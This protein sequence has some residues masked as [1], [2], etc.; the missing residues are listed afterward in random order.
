MI[1][2]LV[3]DAENSTSDG[4][5][6]CLSKE[7][8]I[9]IV[10]CVASQVEAIA[11][12]DA[13]DLMLVSGNLPEDGAYQLTRRVTRDQDC[14]NV[15]IL[16]TNEPKAAIIRFLEAGAMGY[17]RRSSPPEEILNQIYSVYRGEALV[18]PD[19]AAA[20][21]VRLADLTSWFEG[22]NL[23]AIEAQNLTR[24]ERE[25]LYLIGR[26]FS[27]QDIANHL[28]IEVGTVKN[29]V[30][31]ILAKLNVSSR[32]E[33]ATYLNLLKTVP[34]QGVRAPWLQ[35]SDNLIS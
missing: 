20:I 34:Y 25:V 8:D 17:V 19:I 35:N 11:R 32:R 1:R 12:I 23:S 22:F 30:H 3:V 14:T 26:D 28:I 24:R 21:I 27:N 10:G 13:C 2:V 5:F 33:A 9:E 31:N 15:L 18:P 29:H 7:K 4:I 16:G 6:A